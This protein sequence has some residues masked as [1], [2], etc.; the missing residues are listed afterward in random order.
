M[1]QR[2]ARVSQRDVTRGWTPLHRCANMAH[3]THAP[4]LAVFEYLLQ[5]GADPAVLTEPSERPDQAGHM[6]RLHAAQ[7]W[8]ADARIPNTHAVLCR[9]SC[10]AASLPASGCTNPE[11]RGSDNIPAT[12][13]RIVHGIAIVYVAGRGHDGCGGG[14]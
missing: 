2:G 12:L 14:G 8:Q 5:R 1:E 10:V 3:H 11:T 4:F 9:Q 7:H 13:S 6:M